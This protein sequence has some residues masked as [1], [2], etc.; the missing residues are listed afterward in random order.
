VKKSKK[1]ENPNKC[2]KMSIIKK[3]F[4]NNSWLFISQIITSIFGFFWIVLLARYL[5]VYDFGTMNFAISFSTIVN[6]FIDLG[7][8]IYI[9]RD[10]TQC[11]DLARKYIG[12]AIP[13]RIFLS[14]VTLIATLT[15]LAVMNF[16]LLT[17][18]IVLLFIIHAIFLST[19]GLF[20]G[21]FQAYCKQKYQ[22]IGIILSSTLT[23]L[24]TLVL[25]HFDFGLISVALAYISG[26]LVSLI[27]LYI[28][29]R[30]ITVLKFEF[31]FSFWKSAIKTSIPFGITIIFST[32][33]YM[34]DTIMLLFMEGSIAVG[35]YSSA[36]KII[37]VFITIYA[38][39]NFV[40]FPLMRKFYKDSNNL[41]MVSYEKSVK[42]MIIIMLPIAILTTIYAYDITTVI[43][44]SQYYHGG[45][46]LRI[47]IWN[48]LFVMVNG[49]S[50]NLLNSSNN[51][52]SVTK[53]NVIGCVLNIL[54]NL[55]SIY[56]LGYIG[57]S[58]TTVITGIIICI[59]M[60]YI[61][62]GC[63]Y[64]PGKV[65]IYDVIKISIAGII[66][67]AFLIL[68]DFNLWITIPLAIIIYSISLILTRS[69]DSVDKA[70]IKKIISRK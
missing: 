56:Y 45:D 36:Y 67:G 42:Y 13:L 54:F 33:Y 66:L 22:A 46:V 1:I 18:E 27:Y 29:I 53:I 62:T 48:V 19:G 9:S 63:R 30:K 69:F 70:I 26:S 34:I 52:S 65:L 43:Y 32:I 5:G 55:V 40:V 6:I 58:I 51:E 8:S 14:I 64:N 61:I 31:D 24:G 60:T 15:I 7:I 50:A 21:V 23:L 44:G 49:A 47:L 20:N 38:V 59:A 68:V 17:I 11:P 12:N 28:N 3:T 4:K 10:L 41:L 25:V 16:D 39:Y 2:V 35:F 37:T 57:A